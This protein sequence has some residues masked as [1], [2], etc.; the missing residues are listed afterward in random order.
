MND[1]GIVCALGGNRHEVSEALFRGE[2]YGMV[3]SDEYQPSGCC[4][5]GQ[6]AG[7]LP[8]IS[9]ELEHYQSRNNQLLLAALADI[10]DI[11]DRAFTRFGADRIG[12]VVGTSTS[13][14]AEGEA[15]LRAC[16]QTGDFPRKYSYRQQALG[17][18]SEFLSAYLGAG[19]PSYT[20][21]TACSSGARSLASARRLL[22]LGLCD[23]VVVGGADS[24]CGM[25]VQGF[26]ALE[27]L[28]ETYCNP[29]SANRDGINIG[30]GAA[31]FVMSRE[32]SEIALLG[33][34]S[35][36]DAHHISAPNPSGLG[37][38]QAMQAALDDAGLSA[39]SIDYLNLHGTATRQNDAMESRAVTQLF[40]SGL[41]CSSTKAI[42]GHTLGAAGAIETGF[43]W[44]TMT[45]TDGLLP[46]HVWDGV[47]DQEIPLPNFVEHGRSL[48]SRPR[49]CMSNS[50]AFGGN[51]IAVVLGRSEDIEM[52]VNDA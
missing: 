21:S 7:E 30:E 23:A 18:P 12:V 19:G 25:T 2:R 37:A 50:F 35:S 28:S 11:V 29:F 16:Q 40:E 20:I 24:L 39:H 45:R 49:I 38:V 3:S 15:S 17:T 36:S 27:A 13:G 14:I 46:P 26:S 32:P 5:V 9:A 51:N 47:I 42:T 10:R 6:V 4:I 22:A 44:L 48:E 52:K 31:L 33:I 41:L 43:C 1:L 34:G 8:T